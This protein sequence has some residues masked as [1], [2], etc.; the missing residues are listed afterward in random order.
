MSELETLV[1]GLK[2]E[3]AVP[4]EFDASFPNT[5]DDDLLGSLMDGFAGAQL[6]GFFGDQSL[7]TATAVVTPD[8]SAAGGALVIAY[9]TERILLSKLRD[10]NSRTSYEA[11]PVKYEIEKSSN[12][13]TEQMKYLR[14]RRLDLLAQALRAARA[15]TTF[16]MTDAYATRA[17][18]VAGY[19]SPSF[20]AYELIGLR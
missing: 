20:Y 1:E 19:G 15:G 12:L 4:G 5:G 10:L 17:A 8:M 18:M 7:D 11:G 3:L 14:Q 9:A 16:Y 2:R 13:L 6:D